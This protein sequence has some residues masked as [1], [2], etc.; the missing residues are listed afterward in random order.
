MSGDEERERRLTS[1]YSN[2]A[3]VSA[4]PIK[5]EIEGDEH[6]YGG[7]REYP[8]V[9]KDLVGLALYLSVWFFW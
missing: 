2:T 4:L 3:L 9:P 1:L 6:V 8:V 5:A 7:S